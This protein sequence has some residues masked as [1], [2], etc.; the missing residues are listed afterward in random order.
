MPGS[1]GNVSRRGRQALSPHGEETYK[2]LL[3]LNDAY[4]RAIR[5]PGERRNFFGCGKFFECLV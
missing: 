3:Y 2:D 1:F 4:K 5:K